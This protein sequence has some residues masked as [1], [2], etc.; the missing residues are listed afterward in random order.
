MTTKEDDQRLAKSAI[1]ILDASA[2]LDMAEA[3]HMT[4][5]IYGSL[6]SLNVAGAAAGV[7]LQVSQVARLVA[8]TSFVSGIFLVLFAGIRSS[9]ALLDS[10]DEMTEALKYWVNVETT[11]NR[12]Q[13]YEEHQS[14]SLEKLRHLRRRM[15]VPMWLSFF[16]FAIGIFII[17]IDIA[18]S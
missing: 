16:C 7:T 2:R 9:R 15:N 13:Y 4:R 18:F 6:F 1:T 14:R 3:N 17:S 12:N 11:N 8:A 10:A 5:W